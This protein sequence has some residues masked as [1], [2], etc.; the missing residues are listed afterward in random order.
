M[1]E[2]KFRV[3]IKRKKVIEE[4]DFI[5][6]SAKF[7]GKWECQKPNAD[8]FNKDEVATRKG[9]LYNLEDV[10]L[11]QYTGLKD[12]RGN[13]IYEYDIIKYKGEVGKVVFKDACFY[14]ENSETKEAILSLRA[15]VEIN[16]GVVVGNIFENKE[17][18]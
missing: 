7:A 13:E 10:E 17:L 9:R 12:I 6:L 2:I 14:V 15:C 16:F 11:M 8:L 1:K 5:N 3:W 18:I 4:V